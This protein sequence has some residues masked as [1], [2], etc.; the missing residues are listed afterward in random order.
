MTGNGNISDKE[1][2]IEVANAATLLST[3]SPSSLSAK[4]GIIGG[5]DDDVPID[6]LSYAELN[7]ALE[8]KSTRLQKIH[9]NDE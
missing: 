8:L 5:D 3:S 7:K 1:R 9:Q 4:D 2:A 6:N